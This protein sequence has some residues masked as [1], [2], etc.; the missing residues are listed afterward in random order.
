LAGGT[1]AALTLLDS[2]LA[3]PIKPSCAA[4]M[5]IAALP[6]NRRR[7]WSKG[8]SMAIVLI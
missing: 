4:A 5:V 7:G 8:S 3:A 1:L 6:K 2:V